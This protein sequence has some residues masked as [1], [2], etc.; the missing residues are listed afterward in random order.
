MKCSRIRGPASKIG[1]AFNFISYGLGKLKI[2][3]LT[4]KQLKM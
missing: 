2:I 3:K 1:W 4:K